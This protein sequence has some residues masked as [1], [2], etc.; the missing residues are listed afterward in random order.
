[1]MDLK[2]LYNKVKSQSDI[3]L[4][5]ENPVSSQ[6][7]DATSSLLSD[8]H[9]AKLIS[10]LEKDSYFNRVHLRSLKELCV[11]SQLV[12]ATTEEPPTEHD[13][14]R[15]IFIETQESYEAALDE[16]YRICTYFSRPSIVISLELQEQA[17]ITTG[18]R[19]QSLSHQPQNPLTISSKNLSKFSSI[20]S[21]GDIVQLDFNQPFW[22]SALKTNKRGT[23]ERTKRLSSNDNANPVIHDLTSILNVQQQPDEFDML[24]YS[25][26]EA[27]AQYNS[28]LSQLLENKHNLRSF[29]DVLWGLNYSPV[30]TA[31]QPLQKSAHST[32]EASDVV[33][34]I[35]SANDASIHQSNLHVD[36]GAILLQLRSKISFLK[37]IIYSLLKGRPVIIHALPSNEHVVR[38]TIR[39]FCVFIPGVGKSTCAD[40]V[41]DWQ[42]T[43]LKVAD[44]GKAKIIGYSKQKQIPK[45]IEKYVTVWDY[46]AETVKCPSYSGFFIEDMLNRKQWPDGN[47]FLAFVEYVLFELSMKAWMYYQCCC[48]GPIASQDSKRNVQTSSTASSR[49]QPL[50]RDFKFASMD[51]TPPTTRKI[52]RVQSNSTAP[53]LANPLLTNEIRQHA[54]QFSE[55]RE[56]T[57][58]SMSDSQL[59]AKFPPPN[60][61][62]SAEHSRVAFW[63]KLG[64]HR[65]DV[66]IVEHLVEVVK[67]QQV[68]AI[69]GIKHMVPTI[70]LDYS[71][72]QLFKNMKK[73]HSH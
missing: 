33:I 68:V 25:Q 1:M 29:C 20:L 73:S 38:D 11:A 36:S 64:I 37:H 35:N 47:T 52:A 69:Q 7:H 46:E 42:T 15:A 45:V 12:P 2:G 40:R 34:D 8:Q 22:N 66:E 39:A 44:L 17:D 53:P 32:N 6:I 65:N 63:K 48:V 60:P 30:T 5:H 27:T 18:V 61:P 59:S 58:R 24:W 21:I 31:F 54:D 72:A 9:K 3:L 62:T 50:L 28:S 41:T 10:S 57:R 26:P 49:N 16:L 13:R 19:M 70:R 67:E 23:S 14:L 55:A 71:T 43:N 56:S 4:K 51:Q